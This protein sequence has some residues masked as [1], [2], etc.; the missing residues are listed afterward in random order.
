MQETE[1]TRNA[2]EGGHGVVILE[3]YLLASGFLKGALFF[4]MPKGNLL[5]WCLL[6]PW[7]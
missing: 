4:V 2:P 6:V 5:G 7:R 1:R 3:K